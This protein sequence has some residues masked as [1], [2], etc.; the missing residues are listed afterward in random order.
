VKPFR[1]KTIVASV[2]CG[3]V[4]VILALLRPGEAFDIVPGMMDCVWAQNNV[5]AT[6]PLTGNV[7]QCSP[8]QMPPNFNYGSCLFMPGQCGLQDRLQCGQW[9]YNCESPPKII[10]GDMTCNSHRPPICKK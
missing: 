6:C 2:A 1:A 7:Y 3:S 10:D 5:C 9:T 8:A 4:L